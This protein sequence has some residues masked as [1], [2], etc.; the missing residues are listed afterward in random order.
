MLF[1]SCTITLPN[2]G[3]CSLEILDALQCIVR[4]PLK[5]TALEKGANTL[6]ISVAD[7]PNGAY[8]A[9]LRWLSAEGAVQYSTTQLF[10]LR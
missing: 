7:L 9:R 3:T 8:T 6:S 4:Q 1:R 10:I 2:G 5:Q